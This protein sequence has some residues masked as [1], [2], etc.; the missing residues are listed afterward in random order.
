ML[1]A[2]KN[3]VWQDLEYQMRRT[4]DGLGKRIDAG[5]MDAVVAL[6]ANDIYTVAS[7]EGHLDWGAPYPWIDVESSDPRVDALEQQIAEL[8][9]EG[10]KGSE[11]VKQ[12]YLEVKHMHYQEELKIVAALDAFYQHHPLDYDRH[13]VFLHETRGGCRVQSQGADT[14]EV[15]TLDERAAKLKEYQAEMQAFA[16]FLKRQFF[17]EKT[18]YTTAEAAIDM[19]VEQQTVMRHIQKGHLA[20][21]KRGRDYAI[22]AAEWERF[23]NIPRRAGRPA[24]AQ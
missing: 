12:L 5:I 3:Q 24:K 18:A 20:A 23:K 6:N 4:V 13:L 2:S 21:E 15:R 10:K 16:D 17:G 1:V 7:C 19:G 22:A 8:L 9:Y 14:Q 11:E